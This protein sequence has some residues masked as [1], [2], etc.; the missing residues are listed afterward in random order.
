MR[1][2]SNA[3][4]HPAHTMNLPAEPTRPASTDATH[5]HTAGAR[6]YR[7]HFAPLCAFARA[8][9]CEPHDAEDAVQELFARLVSQGQIERAATIPDNGEQSAFLLARLRTVL[10]KRWQFRTRQRRGGGCVCFSLNDDEGRTMDVPDAHATPD[11][12]QD[13]DWAR[14]VLEKALERMNVELCAAGRPEVWRRLESDLVEE[15][16]RQEVQSGALRAALCRA[17]RRLRDFI[18]EQTGT[19]TEDAARMLGAALA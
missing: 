17:R 11:R 18:R 15:T 16:P 3:V 4:I 12:E 8:R 9:G 10:I 1:S 19:S 5:D 6:L 2:L 14:A 13:R 7:R